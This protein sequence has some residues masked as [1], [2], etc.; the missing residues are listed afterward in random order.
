[1]WI[2]FPP[3]LKECGYV[4]KPQRNR[5]NFSLFWEKSSGRSFYMAILKVGVTFFSTEVVYTSCVGCNR[6][7]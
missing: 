7:A 4:I 3:T 5:N 6:F 2:F 1:M